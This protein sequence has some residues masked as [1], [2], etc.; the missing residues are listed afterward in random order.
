MLDLMVNT[1][2][3]VPHLMERVVQEDKT[4]EAV[5]EEWQLVLVLVVLVVLVLSSS[6]T[7]PDKYLKT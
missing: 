7:Q 3:E 4:P 1:L 5:V 2:L 6:H